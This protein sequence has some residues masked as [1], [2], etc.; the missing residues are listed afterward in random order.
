MSSSAAN[1]PCFRRRIDACIFKL[2]QSARQMG[3]RSR[4]FSPRNASL[5]KE[6]GGE[7]R[8]TLAIEVGKWLL[9]CSMPPEPLRLPLKQTRTPK[10]AQLFALKIRRSSAAIAV[11]QAIGHYFPD[12]A[13]CCK[14]PR[15]QAENLAASLSIRVNIPNQRRLLQASPPA[16]P[17]SSDAI[18]V[19]T[20]LSPL[21]PSGA[22]HFCK[23]EK[24]FLSSVHFS[25]SPS[26]LNPFPPSPAFMHGDAPLSL[27]LSQ[28]GSRLYQVFL[29]DA[30]GR[31]KKVLGK[32]INYNT[33]VSA[34][35]IAQS[36]L[37]AIR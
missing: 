17:P 11:P 33:P 29:T 1:T 21:S 35:S 26:P 18:S 9:W 6:E 25:L 4:T 7:F 15:Q 28:V 20:R 3:H 36:T 27:P 13:A 19:F 37:A 14:K 30:P 22:S 24:I 31:F 10:R 5:S 12:K 23:E 8:E 16:S 2:R 32:K 34:A